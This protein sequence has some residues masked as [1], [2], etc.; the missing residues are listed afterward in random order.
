M[1]TYRDFPSPS[2]PQVLQPY[3]H[4]DLLA[5]MPGVYLGYPRTLFYHDVMRYKDSE[6]R[7]TCHV[8]VFT[9]LLLIAKACKKGG[10]SKLDVIVPVSTPHTHACTHARTHTHTHTHIHTHTHAHTHAH[11]PSCMC[12]AFL[13]SPVELIVW[14]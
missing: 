4:I 8:Y 12:C 3:T 5:P 10:E 2:P 14:L 9:D 7:D 6:G 11:I 1:T 13:C